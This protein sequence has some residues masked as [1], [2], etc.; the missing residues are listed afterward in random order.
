MSGLGQ[1]IATVYAVCHCESMVGAEKSG[2]PMGGVTLQQLP[3]TMIL[4][5]RFQRGSVTPN[6][7]GVELVVMGFYAALPDGT[8]FVAL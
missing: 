3:G 6:G 8:E 5:E 2:Y 7:E 1:M 4:D